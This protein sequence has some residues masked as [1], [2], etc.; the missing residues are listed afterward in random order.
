MI[1]ISAIV[2]VPEGEHCVELQDGYHCRF[3]EPW[4]LK[5]KLHNL[6]IV[7]FID[8]YHRKNYIKC[9]KCRNAKAEAENNKPVKIKS[10]LIDDIPEEK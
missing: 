4:I 8:T 1:N 2:Q 6:D 7:E 10:E 9:Y 5:C 3:L